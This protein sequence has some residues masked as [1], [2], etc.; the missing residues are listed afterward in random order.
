MYATCPECCVYHG[1]LLRIQRCK[2]V[3][4]RF[5]VTIEGE[6]RACATLARANERAA[7]GRRMVTVQGARNAVTDRSGGF[8]SVSVAAR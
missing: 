4:G 5:A 8:G 3:P 6:R 1:S 2:D 7:D